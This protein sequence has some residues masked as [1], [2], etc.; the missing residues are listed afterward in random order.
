MRTIYS[1]RDWITLADL[2]KYV[3]L[4]KSHIYR[5][6]AKGQFP[7]PYQLL[8]NLTA[9]AWDRDEVRDWRNARATS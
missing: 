4:S 3:G 1:S 5:L 6:L 2:P 7:Q 8:P 9:V